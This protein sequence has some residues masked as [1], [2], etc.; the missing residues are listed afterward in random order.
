MLDKTEKEKT[1]LNINSLL[2]LVKMQQAILLEAVN[3]SYDSQVKTDE[4]RGEKSSMHLCDLDMV[5]RIL[6]GQIDS[7]EKR[8]DKDLEGLQKE[9]RAL[10]ETNRMELEGGY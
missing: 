2:H 6:K 10:L 4:I 3:N 5:R 8:I 9:Y 7:L 1:M